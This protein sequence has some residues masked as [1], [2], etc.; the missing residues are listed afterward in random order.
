[1]F[2]KHTWSVFIKVSETHRECIPLPFAQTLNRNERH[3]YCLK[4]GVTLEFL[5]LI[6][7]FLSYLLF[8]R[9]G[10]ETGDPRV[11]ECL[12]CR[13]TQGWVYAETLL[14]EIFSFIR[15]AWPALSKAITAHSDFLQNVLI[16]ITLEWRVGRQHDVCNDSNRPNI[17]LACVILL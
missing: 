16:R 5:D 9:K 17:A 7:H 13:E 2:R 11:L 15:D 6:K 10:A 4:V 1:L 12:L 14:N 3:R 8:D